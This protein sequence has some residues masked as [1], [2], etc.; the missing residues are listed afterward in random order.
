M[1]NEK[2]R[3]DN[4]IQERDSDVVQEKLA[5]NAEESRSEMKPT[6]IVPRQN[7]SSD[8]SDKE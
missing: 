2:E 4:S 3:K 8:D 1:A 5:Q 7:S 6:P